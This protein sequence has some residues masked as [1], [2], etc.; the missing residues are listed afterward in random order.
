MWSIVQCI[1]Q[2]L[3]NEINPFTPNIR[4]IQGMKKALNTEEWL[5][6]FANSLQ[7]Y[8]FIP[9]YYLTKFCNIA[10]QKQIRNLYK[11]LIYRYDR[12]KVIYCHNINLIFFVKSGSNFRSFISNQECWPSNA[13]LSQ[14]CL[15]YYNGTSQKIV[16]W[17]QN[18]SFLA[19]KWYQYFS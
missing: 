14:H 15:Y 5:Y 18:H 10:K 19:T 16:Q 1:A 2:Y 3:S 6:V 13:Q 4:H 9:H 17:C 7:T 8:L 11:F 12:N